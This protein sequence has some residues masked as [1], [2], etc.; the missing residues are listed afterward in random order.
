MRALSFVT[1]SPLAMMRSPCCITPVE[2]TSCE[3][4]ELSSM[5]VRLASNTMLG[6]STLS[7]SSRLL[8]SIGETYSFTECSEP[9]LPSSSIIVW[10]SKSGMSGG[11]SR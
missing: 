7:R 8:M 6:S 11:V 3:M 5:R 10:L 1:V 4:R 9:M 2:V